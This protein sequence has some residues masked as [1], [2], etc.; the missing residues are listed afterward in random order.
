MPAETN[1][2]CTVRALTEGSVVALDIGKRKPRTVR[3]TS[4]DSTSS[5][6]AY[7]T[8]GRVR[9]GHISGGVLSVETNGSVWFQ[10]TMLQNP[11]PVRGVTV[12]GLA[13]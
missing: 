7:T 10:A 12:E 13:N 9:P 4:V 5:F 2:A 3:V 8:S 11:V 1:P 6:R